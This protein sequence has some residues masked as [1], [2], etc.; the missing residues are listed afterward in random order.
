MENLMKK[1][2]AF[3]AFRLYKLLCNPLHGATILLA[4]FLVFPACIGAWHGKTYIEKILFFAFTAGILL[5]VAELL[6]CFSYRLYIGS[7]Y[8]RHPRIPFKDLY[9]EPH[10]YIPYVYKKNFLGQ[11]K[12]NAPYPLHRGRYQ[13]A[14]LT[15]NTL[16]SGNR[17]IVTPKPDGLFRVNCLGASTTANY[18]ECDGNSHSYPMELEKKLSCMLNIPVEVNNCGMG[19]YNSAEI[20]IRFALQVIDTDP[21]AVVIYHAYNDISAYLTKDFVSDYSH[22]RKNLGDSYWTYAI[23]SRIPFIPFKF[24]DALVSRWIPGNI[25]YALLDQVSKGVVD[26]TAN[27]DPGLATYRR[28][29]QHII[30][31]CRCNNIKVVLSTYCHFLYDGIKTDPLHLTYAD[32]V[33]KE[34]NIMRE[35]AAKNELI[36]VDNDTLMPKDAKYF[37]D[38]VHFTPEGMCRLATNI[39]QSLYHAVSDASPNIEV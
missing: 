14:Q 28:N 19:G 7:A 31:L 25:R 20:F 4:I 24:V 36:L 18:I 23:G 32:I 15:S 8:A 29:I 5:L 30:D 3:F 12:E 35:L 1:T 11:K 39:A 21:D 34:N 22:C 33:R 37:V 9:I 16:P 17:D 6:F 27:P 10:P 13:F 2:I 26:F 38:S